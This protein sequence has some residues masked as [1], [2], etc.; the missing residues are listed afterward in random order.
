MSLKELVLLPCRARILTN[1]SWVAG[2]NPSVAKIPDMLSS[3]WMIPELSITFFFFRSFVQYV[4]SEHLVCISES[5]DHNV[6]NVGSPEAQGLKE[7]RCGFT[8]VR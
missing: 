1:T 4:P 7:P 3:H 5:S 6:C 8:C 2:P